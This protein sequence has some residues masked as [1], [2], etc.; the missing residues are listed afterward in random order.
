MSSRKRRRSPKKRSLRFKLVVY[1][2][3]LMAPTV[4][5]GACGAAQHVLPT[6]SRFGD[7]QQVEQT[8]PAT[9]R[10]VKQGC[11]TGAATGGIVGVAACI[12]YGWARRQKKR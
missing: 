2:C 12:A 8:P 6:R 4:I 10:T 1:A 7:R 3:L 11:L 5:G 9:T